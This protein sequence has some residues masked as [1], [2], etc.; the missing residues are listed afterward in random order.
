M[1][2]ARCIL[3]FFALFFGSVGVFLWGIIAYPP[4]FYREALVVIALSTSPLWVL[5]AVKLRGVMAASH[6]HGFRYAT[7][8]RLWNVCFMV[9]FSMIICAGVA[10][11]INGAFDQHQATSQTVSIADKFTYK[12]KGTTH[13]KIR[14]QL[15]NNPYPLQLGYD[16]RDNVSYSMYPKIRPG[17]STI[18]LVIRPGFLHMPWVERYTTQP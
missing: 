1:S 7:N 6:G 17:Q 15:T 9:P 18:T 16:E 4:I 2:K 5:M 12:H 14:Y 3:I 11:I 13:Y 8:S 10:M